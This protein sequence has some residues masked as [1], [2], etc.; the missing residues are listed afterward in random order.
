MLNCCVLSDDVDVSRTV[1]LYYLSLALPN[2]PPSLFWSDVFNVSSVQHVIASQA[3]VSNTSTLVGVVGVVL[4]V[5]STIG[6][7]GLQAARSQSATCKTLPMQWASSTCQAA[8]IRAE[9][10]TGLL[11]LKFILLVGNYLAS[12]TVTAAC[13]TWS[14][15]AEAPAVLELAHTLLLK[16]L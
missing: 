12:V 5:F 9:V 11:L 4:P 15:R 2:L 7:L 3:I 6:M 16:A 1:G 10:C 8:A 13:A 14:G